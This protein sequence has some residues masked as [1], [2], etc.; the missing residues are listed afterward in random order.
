MSISLL[1][2]IPI[3]GRNF[4]LVSML[5]FL[6]S[7]LLN[8]YLGHV[9]KVLLCMQ[10]NFSFSQLNRFSNPYLRAFRAGSLLFLFVILSDSHLG[11]FQ[12]WNFNQLWKSNIRVSIEAIATEHISM[13]RCDTCLPAQMREK[14]LYVLEHQLQIRNVSSP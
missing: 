1:P 12:P 5:V 4:S 13:I 14:F 6:Q 7:P 11:N 3:L 2:A 8:T 9:H 10:N